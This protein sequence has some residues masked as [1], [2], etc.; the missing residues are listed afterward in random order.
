[1]NG[2]LMESNGTDVK[3]S[4]RRRKPKTNST[5]SND[6][7]ADSFNPEPPVTSSAYPPSIAPTTLERSLAS[8]SHVNGGPDIPSF[9]I[10]AS[11]SLK[12][13]KKPKRKKK[14]ANSAAA[15]GDTDEDENPWMPV[16]SKKTKLTKSQNNKEAVEPTAAPIAPGTTDV[17][18]KKKRKRR[19]ECVKTTLALMT[20]DILGMSDC[21]LFNA[22]FAPADGVNS[23]TV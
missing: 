17:S 20:G 6:A 23:S 13:K 11:S 3:K 22:T 15:D 14:S 12:Q 7:P 10:P 19:S 21:L 18:E 9:T 2:M 5:P 8:I 16:S 1:M 4:T